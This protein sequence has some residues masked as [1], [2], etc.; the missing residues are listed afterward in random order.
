MASAPNSLSQAAPVLNSLIE[1]Y[2][3]LS[4]ADKSG[5]AS[6]NGL[7]EHVLADL[8]KF[9]ALLNSHNQPGS[10]IQ[11]LTAPSQPTPYS[12]DAIPSNVQNDPMSQLPPDTL[13]HAQSLTSAAPMMARAISIDGSG[14][15]S[16]NSP[17]AAQ[18]TPPSQSPIGPGSDAIVR[19]HRYPNP[20][21][22]PAGWQQASGSSTP[23]AVL[24]PDA[25][26]P[27]AAP[28]PSGSSSG[29][30]G[31]SFT[32]GDNYASLDQ[33]NSDLESAKDAALADPT[34]PAKQLAFQEAAEKVQ[35]MF[36]V[37]QQLSSIKASMADA[38][39]K[40][41]KVSPA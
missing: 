31:T 29:F 17:A 27:P 4:Q 21:D 16:G 34:N 36:G 35:I 32:S 15:I 6:S 23:V 20:T 37:L 3:Q 25:W 18:I 5:S 11:P 28:P 1:D 9:R 41:M 14:N 26:Q 7:F 38:A 33:A 2:A 10:G 8:E 40:A 22:P 24:P 30:G 39:I 19:D 12:T 13:N